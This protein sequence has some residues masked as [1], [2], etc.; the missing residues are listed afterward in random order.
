M[1][2]S[3]QQSAYVRDDTS[4]DYSTITHDASSP[5]EGNP[6]QIFN[7]TVEFPKRGDSTSEAFSTWG[8]Y[9]G[10]M[11]QLGAIEED[12][13]GDRSD[14]NSHRLEFGGPDQYWLFEIVRVQV[15]SPPIVNGVTTPS[16]AS[17]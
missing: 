9:N 4:Y 8:T 15:I 11:D 2:P 1:I 3:T 7:L 17:T 6:E 10:A 5:D 14:T 12:L 16:P 13:S